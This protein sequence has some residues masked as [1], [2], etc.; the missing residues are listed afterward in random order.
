MDV[1]LPAVVAEVTE[2][3]NAYEQA[4]VAGDAERLD[5]DFW[6]SEL[7]VRYGVNECLYGAEAI[8][9]WRRTAPPIPPDRRLGPTVVATFGHD[10]ACVSTEFRS[11]G[12]PIAGRQ[13]QTWVRLPEG[14]RIVA[15]H[16]SIL[17]TDAT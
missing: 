4:L 16:V 3:F 13:S 15:A 9:E 7:T 2:R 10:L 1:N 6:S 5:A 17:R 14:W 8:A 11:G 12:A